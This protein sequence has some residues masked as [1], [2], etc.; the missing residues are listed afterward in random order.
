[1]V[2]STF[3]KFSGEFKGGVQVAFP[4]FFEKFRV[5]V[6]LKREDK[7]PIA[8]KFIIFKSLIQSDSKAEDML[9]LYNNREDIYRVYDE[10]MRQFWKEFGTENKKMLSKL[11]SALNDLRPKSGSNQAQLEFVHEVIANFN[12]LLQCGMKE[13]PAALKACKHVFEHM[14]ERVCDR[15]LIQK[16]LSYDE[17]DNYYFEHPRK[18]LMDVPSSLRKIFERRPDPVDE[19][20]TMTAKITEKRGPTKSYPYKGEKS[21]GV[22]AKDSPSKEAWPRGCIF[23]GS[24][25]HLSYLCHHPVAKRR[26]IARDKGLCFNCMKKGCPGVAYCQK[27]TFCRTCN[28][29]DPKRPKH[30]SWI[31]NYGD[32]P[33][34]R[35]TQNAATTKSPPKAVKK[36]SS[37]KQEHESPKNDQKKPRPRYERSRNSGNLNPTQ[38]AKIVAAL[39]NLQEANEGSLED[40][41]AI[42]EEDDD[43]N[44]PGNE[45]TAPTS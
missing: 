3:Q 16:K 29:I 40:I 18:Q 27:D 9:N 39:A 36:E 25:D 19:D 35:A 4:T 33:Y 5:A 38:V 22:E 37:I 34:S 45:E 44:E 11:Q 13:R 28:G 20:I 8:M 12:L 32:N 43:H 6:H 7:V 26:E 23:C 15:F 41:K 31:C 14:D 30:S 17:L 42:T 10:C 24:N 2:R 1:M 21:K